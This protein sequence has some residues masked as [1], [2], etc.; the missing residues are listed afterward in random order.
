MSRE[1][2]HTDFPPMSTIEDLLLSYDD[3]TPQEREQADEYLAAHP[4]AQAAVRE[5]RRLRAVLRAGQ[6]A[7]PAGLP[8]DADVAALLAALHAGGATLPSHLA[9]L[10]DRVEA[11]RELDAAFD[12]R[13]VELEDRLEA[14]TEAAPPPRA[15][16]E[17][18]T[19]RSLDAPED[20]PEAETESPRRRPDRQPLRS[21]HRRSSPVWAA[22]F[23]VFAV[24]GLYGVLFVAS[25]T[26]S[27]A[28]QQLAALDEVR[29]APVGL[30]LRGA[31]G[32]VDLV[33]EH[34]AEAIEALHGARSTTLGLFPHYHPEGLQEALSQLRAATQRDAPD[35]AIGLEARFLKG[36]LYLHLGEVEAARGAFETVVERQGPSAPDARV[37]LREM[38][39]QGL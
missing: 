26:T 31:D 15:H 7:P 34:Y 5:G 13:C 23:A 35:G 8:S 19:G 17:A 1:S 32:T 37:L 29:V 38:D 9:D 11:G 39:R 4:E 24:V 21:E 18:L 36:R 20:S 14:V 6:P 10:R 30:R 28:H 27:P 33:T 25:E 16:F 22:V 3:L 2:A 12:A